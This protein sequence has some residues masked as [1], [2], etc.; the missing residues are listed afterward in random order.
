MWVLILTISIGRGSGYGLAAITTQEFTSAEKC[1]VAGKLWLD[2][3]KPKGG[4]Y[5]NYSAV[6]V[7]R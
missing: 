5:S 1:G 2:E 7:P 3:N 6:C 4:P